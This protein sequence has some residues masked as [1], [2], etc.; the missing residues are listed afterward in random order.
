MFL[1]S[2]AQKVTIQIEPLDQ[3][4]KPARIDGVPQ[5]NNSDPTIGELVPS[6]DGLTASFTTAGPL[7]LTQ[8]SC[9]ADADLGE[10]I[11]TITAV[12]DIQVEA[13]EAVTL[14]LKFGAPEPK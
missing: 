7:G 6:A 9:S 10:G 12:D 4:E 3:Y 1:L 5:W 14:G 11:R 8:I 13:S 2:N